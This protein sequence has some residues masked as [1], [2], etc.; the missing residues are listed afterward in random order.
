MPMLMPTTNPEQNQQVVAPIYM[1]F[2]DLER[3]WRYCTVKRRRI[4]RTVAYSNLSITTMRGCPW[5]EHAILNVGPRRVD[6]MEG[7]SRP[8]MQDWH[9]FFFLQPRRRTATE[10]A[11]RCIW[12][13]EGVIYLFYFWLEIRWRL[14]GTPILFLPGW[15][16]LWTCIFG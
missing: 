11:I 16:S 7:S 12:R 5:A 15:K 8:N 4:D 13:L 14:E 1:N 6:I 9:F 2:L 3:V 10:L